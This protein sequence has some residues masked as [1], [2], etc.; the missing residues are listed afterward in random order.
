MRIHQK[1]EEHRQHSNYSVAWDVRRVHITDFIAHNEP[2][3]DEGLRTKTLFRNDG[4][5][6][7]DVEDVL[8][9]L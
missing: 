2:E 1:A 3:G 9:D 5:E 6:G 4:D 7:H 8:Q